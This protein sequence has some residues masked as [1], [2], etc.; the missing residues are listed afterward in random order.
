MTGRWMALAAVM[1]GSASPLLGQVGGHEPIE[2]PLR[3]VDGRLMV[4]V[5][6]ADGVEYDFVLGLGMTFITE[7]AATRMGDGIS[8]LTIGGAP[9]DTEQAITVPD[10]E[11]AGDEI[12]PAGL[13][14]GET[15][16]NF[17]VLIDAPN[18]RLILKPI[19]RSVRW[20]GVS[21]SNPVALTLFHDVL[22]RVDVQVEGKVFGAL[23]DL[24]SPDLTVNEPVSVATGLSG[25]RVESFRMGYSGWSDLPFE[26][27]DS[28]IF[29]G[30]DPE[31]NGFVIVGASVAYDCAIAISWAHA[32][33][34]TCLR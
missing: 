13:L 2:V 10:A 4:T 5:D 31:G 1:V 9:V 21:L 26:V 32:E 30:W 3:V 15:L 22:A 33:L 29:Q 12:R 17:D 25:D 7:T 23:L 16:R 8:S 27:T 14:G 20:D 24:A 6:G 19:G 34:R 28:E 11:L 18:E